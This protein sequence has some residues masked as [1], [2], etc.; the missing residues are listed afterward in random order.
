VPPA[1]DGFYTCLC[2]TRK[3]RILPAAGVPFVLTNERAGDF[4]KTTHLGRVSPG[5]PPC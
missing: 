4:L 2:P 1:F 5:G 3:F